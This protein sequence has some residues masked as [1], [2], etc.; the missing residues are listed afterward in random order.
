MHLPYSGKV[1][2]ARVRLQQPHDDPFDGP[3]RVFAPQI[4]PGYQVKYV[5]C[6]KAHLQPGFVR[7]EPVVACLVPAQR[8]LAV[9]DS[10]FNIPS[11]DVPVDRTAVSL[12]SKPSS[13]KMAPPY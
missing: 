10:V 1:G 4:E 5:V 11:P 8:V 2:N 12:R 9:L 6:E 13:V 7:R 3:A